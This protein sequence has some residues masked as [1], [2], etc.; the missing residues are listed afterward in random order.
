MAQA[1]RLRPRTYRPCERG[2]DANR[3]AATAILVLV[4]FVVSNGAMLTSL[5]IIVRGTAEAGCE[6]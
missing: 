6:L 2:R 3:I 4:A 1:R 5:V